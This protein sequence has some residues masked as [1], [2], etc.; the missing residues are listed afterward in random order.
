MRIWWAFIVAA[1][2]HYIIQPIRHAAIAIGHGI[3]ALYNSTIP[4][5]ILFLRATPPE[6]YRRFKETIIPPIKAAAISVG[7]SARALYLATIP[8]AIQSL[9]AIFQ[10]IYRRSQDTYRR[11]R[12]TIV[13]PIKRAN[14]A[15]K[16]AIYS[17]ALTIQAYAISVKVRIVVAANTAKGV[18]TRVRANG[19]AAWA[20]VSDTARNARMR[21]VLAW[22]DVKLR[23]QLRWR[24][25]KSM[26]QGKRKAADLTSGDS[27]M[28][29]RQQ[30][31]AHR[32]GEGRV[33][34]RARKEEKRAVEEASML[35]EDLGGGPERST[36]C[37]CADSLSRDSTGDTPQNCI[38]DRETSISTEK[39]KEERTQAVVATSRKKHKRKHKTK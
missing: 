37:V 23:V 2:H 32:E 13:P 29:A 7:H 18:Y 27:Q 12:D 3:R 1:A 28:L 9:R 4:P 14:A 6:L 21:M 31:Q 15:V 38:H 11:L 33:G 30:R 17:S 22:R 10:D 20:R 8:S 26:W 35:T 39:R 16:H 19:T 24:S 25:V 34:R 36:E 5:T